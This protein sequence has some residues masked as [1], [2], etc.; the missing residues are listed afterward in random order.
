LPRSRCLRRGFERRQTAAALIL[1]HH[2]EAA[3]VPM[4]RTGGGEIVMMKASCISASRLRIS[5]KITSALSP[6]AAR[7][8]NGWSGEKMAPRWVRW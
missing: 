8:W 2:L 7:S 4:P 3:G 5:A 1:H 6:L